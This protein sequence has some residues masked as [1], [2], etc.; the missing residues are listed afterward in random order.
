MARVRL[1][2]HDLPNQIALKA[3]LESDGHEVSRGEGTVHVVIVDSAARAAALCRE[4][5]TLILCP[6][7]GVG[8]AVRA[9]RL[10]AAGYI[11]LPFQPGEAGVMVD[12][13]L[14]LAQHGGSAKP[15]A[16]DDD[17]IVPLTLEEVEEVHI[18]DTLRRCRNNQARA[19]REL[20]IGRNTLWR[21]LNQ[22]RAKS[23]KPLKPEQT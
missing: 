13:A 12:R 9:M 21:K 11:L 18:L 2:I 19:A 17:E 4:I 6:M 15:S 3:M 20:G 7:S 23:A 1:D 5:P 10:G 8:D 14:A 22:I 16:D